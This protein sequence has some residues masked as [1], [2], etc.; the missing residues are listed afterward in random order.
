MSRLT[1]F[2][3]TPE[4]GGEPPLYWLCVCGLVAGPRSPL[5][6]EAIVI[7]VISQRR[8]GHA[9][10]ASFIAVVVCLADRSAAIAQHLIPDRIECARCTIDAVPVARIGDPDGPGA[11]PDQPISFAV[12][13]R[14]RFWSVHTGAGVLVFDSAG[15]FVA[16]VGRMGQGP[17]EFS[18]PRMAFPLGDSVIIYDQGRRMLNVIG[19]DFTWR[20]SIEVPGVRSIHDVAVLSWPTGVVVSADMR[21]P[22]NAGWPLHIL[23]V[24]SATA[25]VR[26]SFG[27][28]D[29]ILLPMS[30]SDIDRGLLL[31][32]VTA[33]QKRIAASGS[34]ILWSLSR[35]EYTLMK[36]TAAGELVDS[37]RRRANWFPELDNVRQWSS[38]H[39]NKAPHP[40]MIGVRPAD[41]GLLWV[42]GHVPARDWRQSYERVRRTPR[43]AGVGD[44]PAS[45]RPP[46]HELYHSMIEI[47]DP[48]RHQVV[49]RRAVDSHIIAVLSDGGVAVYREG[50]EGQPEVEI[51]T[52][53]LRGADRDQRAAA[54][55]TTWVKEER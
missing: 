43:R 16:Q 30:R 14:K 3:F 33:L 37:Y 15:R 1:S 4:K 22:D 47:I 6:C 12:D 13:S 26:A 55:F 44:A 53:H 21:A 10:F 17:R 39:A 49:A 52:F 24:S 7:T 50:T 5:A 23:D 31:D 41:D 48:L 20:R 42:F 11:L 34:G 45:S 9:L 8:G 54:A 38:G 29:G 27:E 18:W 40:I 28:N 25:R 51:I 36:W 32:P 2:D 19:P 35:F 46:A